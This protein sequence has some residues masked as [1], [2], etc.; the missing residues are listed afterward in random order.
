MKVLLVP[1]E[2]KKDVAQCVREI[3]SVLFQDGVEVLM[4]ERLSYLADGV[5]GISFGALEQKA[6][7][8]DLVITI[9][10]DGT[11]IHTAKL[12]LTYDK[13][14]LG[15][16]MG[17]IGFLASLERNQ[18]DMLRLLRRGEYHIEQRMIVKA[19]CFTDF[20][21]SFLALNDIVISKGSTAHMIDLQVYCDDRFVASYRADGVIVATPTG[22]TAYSLSA[23]GAVIDP[24]VQGLLL[25]PIA[26]YSLFS[27]SMLFRS[28]S[29]LRII[30]AGYENRMIELSADGEQNIR[31]NSG[32]EICLEKAD[33]T[34]KL[35]NLTGKR[36][37]EVIHDKMLGR[38]GE[39]V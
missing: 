36:F 3:A 20:P 28:D 13:P 19:N 37:Y 33:Q 1:N 17:R 11:I 25:T 7:Q 15:I 32:E 16:N 30:P 9:G 2:D 8:C 18:I 4:D 5:M 22:S 31:L 39:P 6:R 10:G 27:K 14:L 34:V 12:L 21:R 24:A 29:K 38:F 26:P 35:I 23:G